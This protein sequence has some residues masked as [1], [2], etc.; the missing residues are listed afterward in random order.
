MTWKAVT[1]IGKAEADEA[2][3]GR[4]GPGLKSWERER[5]RNDLEM[6]GCAERTPPGDVLERAHPFSRQDSTSEVSTL[7]L[8]LTLGLFSPSGMWV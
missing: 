6:P 5:P 4:G 3:G 7:A 8:P 2:Q 1:H